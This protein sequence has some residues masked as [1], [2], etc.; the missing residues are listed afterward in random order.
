VGEL[1]ERWMAAV[2]PA[3]SASTVRET[4][5]LMRCHLLLHL[6]HIHVTK[7]TA[8]ETIPTQTPG[9]DRAIRAAA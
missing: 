8:T 1:L 6:G 9:G 3:W 4:R 5:S 2:S 7:L